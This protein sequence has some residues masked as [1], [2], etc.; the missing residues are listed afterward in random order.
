[1]DEKKLNQAIID[2]FKVRQTPIPK[3]FLETMAEID[4]SLLERSWPSV[5]LSENDA[6]FSNCWTTLQNHLE[7]LDKIFKR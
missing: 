3:S 5:Q 7:K 1:M 2:T 4:T 6:S